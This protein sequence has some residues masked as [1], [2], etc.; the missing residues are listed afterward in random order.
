MTVF[1]AASAHAIAAEPA[2]YVVVWSIPG[3]IVAAQIG[4]RLAGRLPERSAER[5]VA[6]LFIFVAALVIAFPTVN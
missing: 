5:V 2:W 3:V 4:P 6:A 1:F